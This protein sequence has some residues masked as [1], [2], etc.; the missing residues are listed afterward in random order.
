LQ[1]SPEL[2]FIHSSMLP[3]GAPCFSARL[4][5]YVVGLL[6]GLIGFSLLMSEARPDAVSSSR[7]RCRRSDFVA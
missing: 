3:A 6:F 5:T 7:D 4:L 2:I 1:L